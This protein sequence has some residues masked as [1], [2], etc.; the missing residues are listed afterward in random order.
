M[1]EKCIDGAVQVSGKDSDEAKE[2]KLLAFQ[3]GQIKKLV[4]KPVIAGWGLN[5]Q[6]CSH[7]SMFPSHSFEQYYQ[8]V[9]RCYRFGQ[10]KPVS[11]HLVLSDG[12]RRIADN[13][14]RK[15]EQV[16]TM[17]RELV[18]HMQDSLHLVSRDNFSKSVEVPSWL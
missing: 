4:T 1:L 16:E 9:R 14:N 6:H 3:D 5:W 18:C 11:V 10:K 17:F 13:L 7:T 8:V 12:E 2:E 15:K